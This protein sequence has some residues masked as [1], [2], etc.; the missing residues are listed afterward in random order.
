MPEFSEVSKS[1]DE[2]EV[3]SKFGVAP[4]NYFI[5]VGATRPRKNIIGM[6]K[7][8]ALFLRNDGQKKMVLAGKIDKRF[9]DVSKEIV[10]LGIGKNIVQTD[11]ISNE[12]KT[13][14]YKNSIALIFASYYE[15]FGFPVLEAQSLGVP[16]ITSKTSSLPEVGGP[17]AIYVDPYNIAEIAEGIKRIASDRDLRKILIVAGHENI[18]RFSW[19]K[20]AQETMAVLRNSAKKG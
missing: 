20:T 2:A 3:L 19:K 4:D 6:L 16:V 15:G 7:A 18:K 8:F 12:E 11:F 13:A 5:Y 10:K 1:D 9:I 17:A 14:L